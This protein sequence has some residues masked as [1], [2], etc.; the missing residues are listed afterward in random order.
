MADESRR[1]Q[2]ARSVSGDL[3]RQR[4]PLLR[5]LHLPAAEERRCC[6]LQLTAG[7]VPLDQVRT[8]PLELVYAGD[9]GE[10]QFR[11]YLDLGRRA[12]KDARN[13]WVHVLGDR[14]GVPG[15]RIEAWRPF[16]AALISGVAGSGADASVPDRVLAEAYRGGLLPP[17]SAQPSGSDELKQALADVAVADGVLW[18]REPVVLRSGVAQTVTI[19]IR[20]EI[21]TLEFAPGRLVVLQRSALRVWLDRPIGP[22][23]PANVAG[24]VVYHTP[25]GPQVALKIPQAEA[26]L[27]SP[28]VSAFLRNL[29]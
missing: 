16:G 3:P 5:V 28:R 12:G 11:L 19:R 23:M 24:F 18:I 26:S 1:P 10:A 14:L 15:A 25:E 27:L 9:V 6:V 20:P 8:G 21:V 2:L 29:V 17:P 22:C 4:R 7:G 13:V